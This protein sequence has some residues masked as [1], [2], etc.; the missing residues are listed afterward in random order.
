VRCQVVESIHQLD[1]ERWDAV[2]DGEIA[3]S[4]RWQRAME[5]SFRVTR[6]R[7]VLLEDE[8]GPLATAVVNLA[9]VF[10]REGWREALLRR[11]TVSVGATFSARHCGVALRPGADV[12]AALRQVN[13][14]LAGLCRRETRPLIGVSN[15]VER[16]LP[17]WRSHGYVAARQRDHMVLDLPVRSYDQY[18]ERLPRKDRAELRRVRRKGEEFGVELSLE[19]LADQGERLFPLMA[20]IFARHGTPESALPITPAIFGAIARELPGEA[21]VLSGRIGGQLAGFGL[22]IRQRDEMLW[23]AAGLRYELARPSCLYFV[24]LDELIRWSI[25]QGLR[26]IYG[27][28]TN[29]RQKA[30]HG[31]QPHA[32]WFCVR[33]HPGPLNRALG[34]A[35]EC[36]DWSSRLPAGS[37]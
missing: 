26:R 4:H 20:E 25:D 1:P 36:R 37:A 27:G 3:M 11:L 14:A 33:A 24:L 2:A 28:M 13:S 32:R 35:L 34:L 15:V 31:F 30:G 21:F 9:G 29:E 22:G 7:Y 10:G 16:D 8:R 23:P 17:I 19:P 12:V 18:L 5:V 6:P